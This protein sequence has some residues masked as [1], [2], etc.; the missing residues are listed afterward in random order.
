LHPFAD[1]AVK[2]LMDAWKKD[3]WLSLG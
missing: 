2:E 1:P 3:F